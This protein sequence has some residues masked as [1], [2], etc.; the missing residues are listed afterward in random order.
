M[1]IEYNKNDEKKVMKALM[2]IEP[3]HNGNRMDLLLVATLPT[4]L[5][6]LTTNS[7][8]NHTRLLNLPPKGF[9]FNVFN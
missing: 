3:A 7:F 9:D 2:G 8:Q 6:I 4:E 5:Y 1:K